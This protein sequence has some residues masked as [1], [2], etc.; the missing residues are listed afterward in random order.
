[1]RRITDDEWSFYV[2]VVLISLLLGTAYGFKKNLEKTNEYI[3]AYWKA[4]NWEDVLSDEE[5]FEVSEKRLH[6]LGEL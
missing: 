2:V 1:M 3:N 5:Y 4:R 6:S